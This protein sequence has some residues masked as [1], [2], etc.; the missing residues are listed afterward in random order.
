L[1]FHHHELHIPGRGGMVGNLYRFPQPASPGTLVNGIDSLVYRQSFPE[2]AFS[3]QS[4]TRTGIPPPLGVAGLPILACRYDFK[5]LERVAPGLVCDS[6]NCDLAS[7]NGDSTTGEEWSLAVDTRYFWIRD[8]GYRSIYS[9]VYQSDVFIGVWEPL[10][11]QYLDTRSY[12]P[13]GFSFA[14]LVHRNEPG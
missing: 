5:R 14:A 10:V 7:R 2:Y 13:V 6:S 9:P 3:L 8:S 11:S 1:D 4:P 12:L